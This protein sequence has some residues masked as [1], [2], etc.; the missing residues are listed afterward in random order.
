MYLGNFV[1]GV[2]AH[3]T[4]CVAVC[5]PVWLCARARTHARARVPGLGHSSQ[6]LLPEGRREEASTGTG[7]GGGN[8]AEAARK[9]RRLHPIP[10]IGTDP[11]LHAQ[12]SWAGPGRFGRSVEAKAQAARAEA[13]SRRRTSGWA[14]GRPCR[15]SRQRPARGLRE[16]GAGAPA[17]SPRLATN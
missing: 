13:F 3:V 5:V 4:L 17:G 16:E 7:A 9:Q 15:E 14:G 1:C 2:C 8:A 12:T 6:P 10:A 11:R